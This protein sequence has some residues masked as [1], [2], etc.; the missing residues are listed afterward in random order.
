MRAGFLPGFHGNGITLPCC[1][2]KKPIGQ[3]TDHQNLESLWN[4]SAYRKFRKAARSLPE[5]SGVPDGCECGRCV[6][7]PRNITI[8]N[9]LFPF[10][11]IHG[12]E[13]LTK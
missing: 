12:G 8:H 6:F 9:F 2:C 3:V 7:R 5:E 4:F 1:Q 11:R 10:N 13:G